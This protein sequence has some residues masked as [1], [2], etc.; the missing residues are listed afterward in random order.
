MACL[1]TRLQ[2]V[3]AR[4]H[5]RLHEAAKLCRKVLQEISGSTGTGG[6][7]CPALGFVYITLGEILLE[8][9]ELEEAGQALVKGLELNALTPEWQFQMLGCFALSGVKHAQGNLAESSDALERAK[10][11]TPQAASLV[12]GVQMALQLAQAEDDLVRLAP[13]AKWTQEQQI[14]LESTAFHRKRSIY[15]EKLILVRLL[16]AQHRGCVCEVHPMLPLV[17]PGPLLVPLESCC[18]SLP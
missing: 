5:G 18:L 14:D 13:I 17:R 15:D 8:R 2:A 7:Q 6:R 12:A 3:V 4:K 16:I 9:N 1:A 11:L 10:A